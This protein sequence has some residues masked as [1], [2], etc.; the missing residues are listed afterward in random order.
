MNKNIENSNEDKYILSVKNLTKL[1]GLNK[2]EAVKMLKAGAEK[3]EVFKKTG[4]T[5][6]IWDMSFDVKQGEIFVIIGL[7][8]SGKSTVIRCLNRLHNPTSGT[9]L[10]DG[11]D[12]GKFS[13]KELT[14]FRRNKISMVFQNFG[15]MSHRD[16]ISNIEYG[17]EIKGISK[18]E[19]E[20][21]AMEVLKMV[22]LEGLEHANINSL[23]GGMKQRVG[24]AR[25]LAN[26]PEILLMDEPF[27]ALDPLVR[28]DMQ[29][30]LLSIQKK[31]KK[32]IIFI[33]HDINE[34]FKLGDKVAIMKDSRL[35]QLDTPENMSANPAD[36]YVR[37]FIDSADKTKVISV[38][39]IMFNPSC[40]IRLKEGAGIA[41][42]E[43]KSNRVSSAYVIDNH[44]KF[45]GI[46]TID[47]ALKCRNENGFLSDYI[48][49]EIPTTSSDA[50]INDILPIAA[51]TKF[52]IAV[53]DNGELMGI[54]SKA[55]ILSTLI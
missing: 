42:R 18:E 2:N 5:S 52:P 44:M 13:Q 15:L 29:F 11:K 49:N 34:A 16:V 38:K 17:L 25:A 27:S 1:Y 47:N 55:S 37:Q 8:G 24:I 22:G 48:F 28:S 4:V 6:A 26:D 41:I 9:I 45:L 40:I 33:T 21:K 54:V 30:E 32:T 46:I 10:F 23:S 12:I 20:K 31:L 36:D 39:Q 43:M 35:I 3:N 14:D 51:N 7:S 50:L 53:I 19:R